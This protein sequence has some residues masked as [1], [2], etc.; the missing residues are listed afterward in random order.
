MC[1]MQNISKKLILG[2]IVVIIALV[3]GGWFWYVKNDGVPYR[4]GCKTVE[5]INGECVFDYYKMHLKE[6]YP[7]VTENDNVWLYVNDYSKEDLL[8]IAQQ[9]LQ[10]IQN[11][12]TYKFQKEQAVRVQ[13]FIDILAKR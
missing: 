10:D 6:W 7:V 13:S 1:P 4:G 5:Y 11:H 9:E 12:K 8:A 2:I 3:A